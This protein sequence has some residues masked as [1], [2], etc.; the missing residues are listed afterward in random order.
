MR[1]TRPTEN[2]VESAILKFMRERG[3]RATRNHVGV[4][5]T[6]YGGT[7]SIGTKGFPDWTFTRGAGRGTVELMHVEAKRRGA[8]PT[9]KQF[10]VMAGLNH[11][12]ELAVWCESLDHFK[13]IYYQYFPE[14][15]R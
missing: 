4:F 15:M 14:E 7:V 1:S 9:P 2:S 11:I 13:T 5:K 3:W 12:G 8:K 10:E 6:T